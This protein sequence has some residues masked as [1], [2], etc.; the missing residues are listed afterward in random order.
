MKRL[1]LLLLLAACSDRPPTSDLSA[2]PGELVVTLRSSGAPLGAIRFIVKGGNIAQVTAAD[3]AIT[4]FTTTDD[5]E[6]SVVAIGATIQG[7]LVRL[8]VPDVRKASSYRTEVVE[9]VDTENQKVAVGERYGLEV[10][11]PR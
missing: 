6:V 3:P 4:V 10:V 8:R 11:Q 2:V 5:D 7:A 1:A 9:L